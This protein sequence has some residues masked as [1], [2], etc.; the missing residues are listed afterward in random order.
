VVTAPINRGVDSTQSGALTAYIYV[1]RKIN[2]GVDDSLYGTEWAWGKVVSVFV[3][4]GQPV[5]QEP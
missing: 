5:N 4:K 3:D 1:F 2:V